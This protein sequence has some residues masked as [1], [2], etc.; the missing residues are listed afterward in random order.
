[1]HSYVALLADDAVCFPRG[2]L[3]FVASVHDGI[4]CWQSHCLHF[5]YSL[6]CRRSLRR[7]G[8]DGRLLAVDAAPVRGDRCASWLEKRI[9]V[10]PVLQNHRIEK[11]VALVRHINAFELLERKLLVEDLEL[12]LWEKVC[13][14]AGGS[15]VLLLLEEGGLHC[16]WEIVLLVPILLVPRIPSLI[17]VN[18][19]P[20]V[21][22]L[23]ASLSEDVAEI[24]VGLKLGGRVCRARGAFQPLGSRHVLG[25][26]SP[27]FFCL[28]LDV[29]QELVPLVLHGQ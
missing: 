27:C 13:H 6:R 24:F 19:V 15:T 21:C 20:E 29:L 3:A 22:A 4:R 7:R 8:W 25:T 9:E 12:F 28:H 14:S 11:A 16:G 23:L 5:P 26:C 10:L 17:D 18:L 2:P 1:M